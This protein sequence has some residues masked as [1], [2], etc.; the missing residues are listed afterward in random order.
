[1]VMDL[2]E[3]PT[4]IAEPAEPPPGGVDAVEEHEYDV[5]PVV[6][7]AVLIGNTAARVEPPE[8]TEPEDTDTAATAATPGEAGEAGDGAVDPE[9]ES[10]A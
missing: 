8:V 5:D 7:D 10:P 3:Q 1:M 6:P 2:G 9:Q 4:P